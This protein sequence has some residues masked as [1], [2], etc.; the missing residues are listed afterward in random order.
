MSNRLTR[1]QMLRNTSLAGVGM[2]LA[3]GRGR[4]QDSPNEKLNIA[5]IAAGGRGAAN[6]KSVSS[7]NIVALCDVDE[8][9]AAKSFETY[10]KAK[11]YFDYRKLL[12][13]RDEEIDAVV[14]STPNHVHAPASVTAMRRGKHC[15]CEKPLTHSVYESRVMA[16]VAAEKNLATQMGTQIHAGSNYRRVVELVQAG[17][18]GPVREVYVRRGPGGHYPGR[19]E[20]TPPVPEGLQWDLW[21]GPAPERPYHPWYV[22]HDWHYFWDFGGG[23]LGN[24]GC[25]YLDLP[26]WALD[27]R[28]PET[29]VATG[30]PVNAESTP[31]LMTIH[32]QFPARGDMPPVRLTWA[33]GA[34]ELPEPL[35]AVELPG[36]AIIAFIGEKGVLAANYTRRALLPEAEFADFEPPEPTIPPS[37]GHHREWI[38]AC[39]TG[40]PT[41]CNFDYAGALTE[42][43]LLGNVAYR[44]GREITWDPE[45]LRVTDSPEA[46]QYIQRDYREG[47][48]L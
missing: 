46:Q 3:S 45:N 30:D 32:W 31:R 8:R 41:T 29:I 43:V 16:Q 40:S 17:A 44:A 2:L 18:I 12:D 35:K 14:V 38:E 4:G 19:P 1:R 25:H 11:K 33:Q 28:H 20:E 22:P 7:E 26:F 5:C 13:E 27:L 24:F 36:W 15:Y 6:L 9:R 10:P 37:V 23:S 39:K 48:T 34:T 42:T 21:L 47:W